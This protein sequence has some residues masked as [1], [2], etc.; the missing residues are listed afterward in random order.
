MTTS[1]LSQPCVGYDGWGSLRIEYSIGAGS[2]TAYLPDTVDGRKLLWRLQSAFRHGLPYRMEAHSVKDSGRRRPC[3]LSTDGDDS[4]IQAS[5]PHKTSQVPE[6]RGHGF[7]DPTYFAKCHQELD[8]LGVPHG[9]SLVELG[10][11]WK[12]GWSRLRPENRS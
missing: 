4:V 2:R 7:T 1:L 11:H 10:M 6:P 9:D 8:A 12:P 5:L 3:S